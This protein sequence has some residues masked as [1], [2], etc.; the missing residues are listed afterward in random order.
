MSKRSSAERRISPQYMIATASHYALAKGSDWKVNLAEI[1]SA[2]RKLSGD[3]KK[4]RAAPSE[5]QCAAVCADSQ[6]VLGSVLGAEE[7]MYYAVDFGGILEALEIA[8]AAVLAAAEAAGQKH[9]RGAARAGLRLYARN[10][11]MRYRILEC[12]RSE[13]RDAARA[14]ARRYSRKLT[15]GVATSD[16]MCVDAER[17]AAL[18]R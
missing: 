1:E 10:I 16:A 18:H 6:E 14:L 3:T 11:A 5:P 8:C 13:G 9:G 12:A 17:L 7:A 15:K 4:L 2:W